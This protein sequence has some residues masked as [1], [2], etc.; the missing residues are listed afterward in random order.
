MEPFETSYTFSRFD[1]M[2]EK[3]PG[4]TALYYLGERYSNGRLSML[5]DRFAAGLFRIGVKHARSGDAL[6][7]EL[8][9]MDRRELRHQ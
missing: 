3:E 5:I 1:E 6:H 9:P 4:N 8:S 2:C 7:P